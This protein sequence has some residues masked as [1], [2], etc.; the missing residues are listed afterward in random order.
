[1]RGREATTRSFSV[2]ENGKLTA[3]GRALVGGLDPEKANC[4]GFNLDK[5]DA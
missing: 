4:G 1:L 5:V 2:D 3:I